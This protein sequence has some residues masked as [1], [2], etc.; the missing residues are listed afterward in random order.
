MLLSFW[1]FIRGYVIIQV[2]GV[3]VERFINMATHKGIYFWDVERTDQGV[4]LQASVKSYGILRLCARKTGCKMKI[5]GKKGY[6]F[7]AHRYRKRKLLLAGFLFFIFSLYFLSSFIWLVEIQGN[8]RIGQEELYIY[9]KAEGLGVGSMKHKLNI[10]EFKKKLMKNFPD[11]S[12]VNVNI[13]G[14][15]ATLQIAE[16]IP[17]PTLIDKSIPC[18]IIAKKDGLITHIATETGTPLVKEHDT[19]LA[20]DVLVSAEVAEKNDA[21]IISEYVHAKA[22]IWAKMYYKISFK[23]PFKYYEKQY[24]G[25]HRKDHSLTLFDKNLNFFGT[26]VPYMNYDKITKHEQVKLS[27]DYPLPIIINTT[28]YREFNNIEKYHTVDRAKELADK[29]LTGRILREFDFAADILN[30]E[31]EFVELP[32]GLTVNA[33]IT[34]N[35]RIDMEVPLQITETPNI[36]NEIQDNYEQNPE[37]GNSQQQEQNPQQNPQESQQ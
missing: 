4:C 2:M 6:P 14:T 31:I 21:G 9:C 13:S 26:G 29:M 19:V 36:L 18:N 1:N 32:D 34:T 37:Q 35:E 33:I 12:W 22:Q 3:S 10:N 8:K 7:I 24:T 17:K 30:K 27:E 25:L 5:V 15:K 11:I 28:L 23:V 16:T 20:G